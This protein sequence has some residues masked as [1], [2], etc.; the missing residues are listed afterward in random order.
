M[1]RGVVFESA[2]ASGEDGVGYTD[3]EAISYRC[4]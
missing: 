3:G 2:R 1:A 4:T